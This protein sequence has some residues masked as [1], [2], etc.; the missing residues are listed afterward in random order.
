MA[1]TGFFDTNEG[2]TFPLLAHFQEQLLAEGPLDPDSLGHLPNS[3][4]VD[5]GCKVGALSFFVEGTHQVWLAEVA[6]EAGDFV[7]RFRSDAPGLIGHQLVFRRPAGSREFITEYTD[8]EASENSLSISDSLSAACVVDESL[9]EGYLV[10]GNLDALEAVLPG[11]GDK[12]VGDATMAVVEPALVQN[13]SRGYVRSLN[14]ANADRVRTTNPEE[15]LP[16]VLPFEPQQIYIGRDCLIGPLRWKAG[17]N[18]SI[19]QSLPDN[20]IVIA[21]EVGGGEGEPCEEVPVSGSEQ[22]QNGS[23]LL[24]GGP[25]CG[26]LVRSINGQSGRVFDILSGGGVAITPGP[27]Q[28]QVRVDLNFTG[29]AV[30]FDAEEPDDSGCPAEA[31]DP[32]CGPV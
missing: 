18:A 11:E 24:T 28:H 12:L 13:M 15:C 16:P 26:D 31:P 17:F 14:V 19:K 32:D 25:S 21:A 1:Q 9:W 27:E 6:R 5:F 30:C 22:P 3:T 20:A 10:T 4:I 23:S 29:L 7:F 2:I 8:V